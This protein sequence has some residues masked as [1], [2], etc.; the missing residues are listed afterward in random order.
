GGPALNTSGCTLTMTHSRLT[1]SRGGGLVADD[2]TLTMVY[3]NFIQENGDT[4]AATGGISLT[5]STTGDLRFNTIAFNQTKTGG[6]NVSGLR[7]STT[8]DVTF[9]FNIVAGNT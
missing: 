9:A 3:N 8:G 4:G 6:G 5:G 2:S 1:T 7:C